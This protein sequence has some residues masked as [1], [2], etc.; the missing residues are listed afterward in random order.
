MKMSTQRGFAR[1]ALIAAVFFG[2][3]CAFAMWLNINWQRGAH[4]EGARDSAGKIY[5][6][7]MAYRAH[8]G[9]L[10]A[11]LT[12]LTRPAVNR[13]NQR[14]GPFLD[15][16]PAPPHAYTGAPWSVYVYTSSTAGTFSITATG[17]GT[18]ITVP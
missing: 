15:K 4:I 8:M 9:A 3:V 1:A 14:A 7:V 16:V 18:T 5:S 2:A 17:D 11:D 13:L 10:P 6:A 12:A